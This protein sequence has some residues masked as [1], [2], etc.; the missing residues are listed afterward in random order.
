MCLLLLMSALGCQRF[1]EVKEPAQ[2][3]TAG[4]VFSDDMNATAAINGIYSQMIG[5]SSSFSSWMTTVLAGAAAD[6]LLRFNASVEE[7]EL[8]TNAI[9]PDNNLV[10]ILWTSA[11]RT[12]YQCNAAIEGL[13]RPSAVSTQVRNQLLGEAHFVRA[14]CYSYLVQSFGDVPLVLTTDWASNQ[15]LGRNAVAEV[16]ERI[17]LDL[18]KAGSLM[19]VSYP[20]AMKGRP[21]KWSAVA[22][23]ARILLLLGRWEEAALAATEVLDKGGYLPL[24]S[25]PQV[26]LANSREAIWQL[27]PDAVN[28]GYVP[29]LRMPPFYTANVPGYYLR[30]DLMM[31]FEPGDRRRSARVDSVLYLGTR[32]YYP[33]KYKSLSGNTEYYVVLRAAELL[34]IRAEARANM[35]YIAEG[36]QDVNA[37]RLRAQLPI[38]SGA[39]SKDELLAAV[40]RERRVELFAEWGHRWYDLKRTG[41][42]TQVLGRLKPD[43][44]QPHDTLWPIHSGQ[45]VLNPAL[46]QNEG[47]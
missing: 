34:L 45:L 29:E 19:S 35:G 43:S 28:Y 18:Q 14:F 25:L 42:A 26:Y 17:L 21:N 11:Y 31:A 27:V 24:P 4:A 9:T 33:G 30:P 2:Q 44:W 37:V 5:G 6:E 16:Y 8:V 13:G 22:F 3:V 47:Y 41:R 1:I 20:S 38:L 7:Q 12:I 40:Y 36:M 15:G 23:S 46:R 32:Y 39:M 10:S